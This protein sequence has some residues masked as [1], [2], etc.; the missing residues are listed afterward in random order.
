MSS[1]HLFNDWG[2]WEHMDKAGHVYSG[3]FQSLLTYKGARWTGLNERQSIYT[4]VG[5]GMLFQTTIEVLDGFSTQWG[6]SIPDMA[7]NTIGVGA[8]ALQQLGWH[9]QRI[10]IKESAWPKNYSNNTTIQDQFGSNPISLKDRA[11]K[12]YGTSLGE[13]LLKDYN[14]QTYWLSFNIHSFLPEQNRI[15]KWMNITIGY[16]ADNMY[17]GFDNKWSDENLNYDASHLK[18]VHQFYLSL[19]ADLTRVQTNNHFLKSILSVL[20]IFKLPAPAI[21]FNSNR[22]L[23]FHFIHY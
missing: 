13:K 2:E 14:A 23:I 8:F 12:L 18:R 16:G 9:E 6:F 19:D 10:T 7:A 4:G 20:N 17:G 21:E 11:G 1:F 22:E 3:Y 5:I 15:P